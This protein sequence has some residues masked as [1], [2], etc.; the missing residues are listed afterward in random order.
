MWFL[1]LLGHSIS[2][3]KSN[4]HC[5]FRIWAY[6]CRMI[7]Q[8]QNI[9]QNSL[10]LWKNKFRSKSFC[11]RTN[12]TWQFSYLFSSK[13]RANNIFFFCLVGVFGVFLLCRCILTLWSFSWWGDTA[14]IHVLCGWLVCISY[15]DFK[16]HTG[17]SFRYEWSSCGWDFSFH[18]RQVIVNHSNSKAWWINNK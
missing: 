8:I 7:M 9:H 3:L 16:G 11:G 6:P 2:K 1:A 13:Q 15:L 10:K 17:R 12:L 4:L 14:K 5:V 18:G